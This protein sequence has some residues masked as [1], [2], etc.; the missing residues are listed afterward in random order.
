M[1]E[2]TDTYLRHLRIQLSEL[3]VTRLNLAKLQEEISEVENNYE[4]QKQERS[5]NETYL[6]ETIRAHRRLL[7]AL[8]QEIGQLSASHKEKQA[9]ID[10]LTG[11]V[12]NSN[13]LLN[14]ISVE[15]DSISYRI[16]TSDKLVSVREAQISE[17]MDKK[18]R[19]AEE[20]SDILDKTNEIKEKNFNINEK[21]SALKLLVI[22]REKDILLLEKKRESV[23]QMLDQ[24]KEATRN[25]KT[26]AEKNTQETAHKREELE[27]K[28]KQIR[29][30]KMTAKDLNS[31]IKEQNEKL[32]A[33]HKNTEE[34]D[35]KISQL[36]ERISHNNAKKNSTEELIAEKNEILQELNKDGEVVQ[37]KRGEI[38]KQIQTLKECIDK[39]SKV[40]LRSK[41]NL[42]VAE[43][44]RKTET[45]EEMRATFQKIT[46]GNL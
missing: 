14:N 11:E 41:A 7:D 42:K 18:N 28:T 22:Q 19:I 21:N 10:G 3:R 25:M 33:E 12:Q 6:E 37:E 35:G 46:S 1:S 31:C 23:L 8:R 30:L 43:Y 40:A 13:L 15:I 26:R 16:E 38:Q 4:V 27:S 44:L 5:E 34:L 2:E 45:F 32:I 29:D 9:V 24:K 39:Y 17:M 20:N 36:K